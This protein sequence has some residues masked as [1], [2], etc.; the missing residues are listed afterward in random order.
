MAHPLQLAF[1][2]TRAV[3]PGFGQAGRRVNVKANWF[4]VGRI[5]G[6]LDTSDWECFVLTEG[7]CK[8]GGGSRGVVCSSKL[9]RSACSTA[10]CSDCLPFI[11]THC[12]PT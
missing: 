5:W 7:L 3:R 8:N 6:R 10:R 9:P 11:P 1:T 12:L 4:K 2:P